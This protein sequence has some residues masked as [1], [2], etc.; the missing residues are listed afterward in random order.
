MRQA[1]ILSLHGRR[2]PRIATLLGLVLTGWGCQHAPYYFYSGAPAC[3]PVVPAPAGSV[4]SNVGDPPTEVIEGGVTSVEVPDRT[5]TVIGSQSQRKV[6]VSEPED[7]PRTAWRRNTQPDPAI[8]TDV[9]G[10]TSISGG[11]TVVR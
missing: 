1:R 4:N 6:V 11:S 9:E 5:T 3:V 2:S 10:A 7:R 8:A